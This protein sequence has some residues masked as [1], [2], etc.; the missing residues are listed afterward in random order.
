MRGQDLPDKRTVV[1]D[2][3]DVVTCKSLGDEQ[4]GEE[5]G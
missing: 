1:A 5:S 3:H 2:N 4:Q